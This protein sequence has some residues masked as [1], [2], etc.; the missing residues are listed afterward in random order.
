[1][2]NVRT[3]QIT[4]AF[5][6]RATLRNYSIW[7][8][9]SPSQHLVSI[10]VMEIMYCMYVITEQKIQLLLC[11]FL[12]VH[13]LYTLLLRYEVQASSVTSDYTKHN[14]ENDVLFEC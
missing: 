10:T 13:I 9:M 6:L 14:D 11:H 3:Y 8:P 4:N 7:V 1:M 12:N 2:C 5:A